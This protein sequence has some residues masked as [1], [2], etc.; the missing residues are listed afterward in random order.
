MTHFLTT[1]CLLFLIYTIA[2]NNLYW[3]HPYSVF[4]ASHHVLGVLVFLAWQ[5]VMAPKGARDLGLVV[6]TSVFLCICMLR[7]CWKRWF[8][9]EF[10]LVKC[11]KSV[12]IVLASVLRQEH[13]WMRALRVSNC[14]ERVSSNYCIYRER[15]CS[16]VERPKWITNR[17]FQ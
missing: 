5:L 2:T 14:V 17:W 1:W 3:K 7:E 9:S 10:H 12:R 15:I 8:R 4:G 11:I 16:S 13:A 6:T